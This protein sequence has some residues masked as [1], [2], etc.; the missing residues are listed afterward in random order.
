LSSPRKHRRENLNFLGFTYSSQ[1]FPQELPVHI[2]CFSAIYHHKL[3]HLLVT[4]PKS[5]VFKATTFLSAQ[6][7]DCYLCLFE[8]VV[9]FEFH[10]TRCLQYILCIFIYSVRWTSKQRELCSSSSGAEREV[11]YFRTSQLLRLYGISGESRKY[12]GPALVKRYWE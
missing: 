4:I 5:V 3:Q 2:S 12:E 1:P 8:E 10:K 6:I 9:L 7:Y 11:F